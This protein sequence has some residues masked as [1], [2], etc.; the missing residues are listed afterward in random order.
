M[1][2][3]GHAANGHNGHNGLQDVVTKASPYVTQRQRQEEAEPEDEITAQSKKAEENEAEDER[4]VKEGKPRTDRRRRL[5]FAAFL[6]VALIGVATVLYLKFG[7]T[8]KIDYFVKAKPKASSMLQQP[9]QPAQ[10][11]AKGQQLA[12]GTADSNSQVEAAIAQMREARRAGDDSTPKGRD[13]APDI[14][15]AATS[16]P[17]LS[18]P[19]DYIAPR[20][21]RSEGA[22]NEIST[23]G[24]QQNR[25]RAQGHTMG[26]P[27]HETASVYADEPKS[28]S[29]PPAPSIEPI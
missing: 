12:D 5:R 19:T 9:G 29:A 6:S 18:L 10:Q 8:T 26:Q 17:G 11:A 15:S 2:E 28:V 27:R 1:I 16:T 22:G 13:N 14:S 3:N 20:P 7:Q 24:Q 25:Q 23:E 21:G 4:T